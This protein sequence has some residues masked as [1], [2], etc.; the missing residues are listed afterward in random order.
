MENIYYIH[1]NTN[2]LP[3]YLVDGIIRPASL[4]KN[5]ENDF[6]N[7]SGNHIILSNK[8]WNNTN[9][10]SIEVVLNNEE[11]KDL[12]Q[13]S[14]DFSLCNTGLPISRI[15]NI[16]FEDKEKAETVIWNINNTVAFVPNWAIQYENKKDDELAEDY[17]SAFI[18]TEDCAKELI[19]ALKRFDRLLGGFAFLKVSAEIN[20]NSSINFSESYFS[21]LAFFNKRIESDLK[22]NNVTIDNKFYKI[23]TGDSKIFSYLAKNIDFSFVE[24]VAK[25]E[26]IEL[27]SKFGV[28]DLTNLPQE[29]LTFKLA[30]LETYGKDNSKSVED[31]ITS[32]LQKLNENIREEIALIY[33]LHVGYNTLRNYYKIENEK[34][35]VKFDLNTKIDF[36][37]IESVYQYA[38]ND[39]K[40]SNDF[41]YLSIDC[42]LNKNKKDPEF[43]YISI[44]N[45]YYPFRKI[46]YKGQTTAIINIITKEISKWFPSELF[47]INEDKISEKIGALISQKI[48]ELIV[49]VTKNTKESF[50]ENNILE[51]ETIQDELNNK[52]EKENIKKNIKD[53]SIVSKNEES[54]TIEEVLPKNETLLFNIEVEKKLKGYN[55]MELDKQFT[56]S[57]LRNYAEELKIKIPKSITKKNDIIS[58]ILSNQD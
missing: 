16:Y 38:F 20:S 37:T 17:P 11:K 6:Q 4:I 42:L 45:E 48:N 41:D 40:I 55:A 35:Q 46:D 22:N 14:T 50:D 53:K 52:Y 8:K 39:K 7:N 9:D 47:K 36:Y 43:K 44:L 57:A 28:I 34:I 29:S 58:M 19:I 1:I 27:Q 26:N 3:H 5:R 56:I 13:I 2:A 24:E 32:L 18:T 30:I 31:L 49:D 15:K 51:I 10:C 33:G 54:N 25:E 21:T 23:F 12:K